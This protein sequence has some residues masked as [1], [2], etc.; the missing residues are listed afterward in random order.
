MM[1]SIPMHFRQNKIKGLALMRL[2]PCF[3]FMA[4]KCIDCDK[5]VI[6]CSDSFRTLHIKGG[7]TS[8]EAFHIMVRISLS[9]RE[10]LM[11]Q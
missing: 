10:A 1:G 5:N 6:T 8:P 11:S 2:T 3:I 7:D 9:G 4:W